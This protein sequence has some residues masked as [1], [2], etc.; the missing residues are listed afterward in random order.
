M[1]VTSCQKGFCGAVGHPSAVTAGTFKGSTV[2]NTGGTLKKGEVKDMV[3]GRG[4][5]GGE[6]GWAQVP[7]SSRAAQSCCTH[8]LLPCEW[9]RAPAQQETTPQRA[10]PASQHLVPIKLLMSFSSATALGW[11]HPTHGT[12]SSGQ[13]ELPGSLL[14]PPAGHPGNPLATHCSITA[15]NSRGVFSGRKMFLTVSQYSSG[16][17]EAMKAF[18]CFHTCKKIKALNFQMFALEKKKKSV[19]TIKSVFF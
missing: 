1:P 11:F 2:R 9:V 12:V 7:Q 13:L 19:L 16:T 18:I 15:G 14:G 3:T 6:A 4:R 5:E 10:S 8:S 17:S